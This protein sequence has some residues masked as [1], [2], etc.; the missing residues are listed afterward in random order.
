MK[1]SLSKQIIIAVLVSQLLLAIG[2]TLAIVLYSRI[3][4]LAGFDIMLE[5][6]ADS[7]LAVI[8]DSEDASQTLILD[9]Q[10]L[11]LPTSDLLEVWDEN[12]GLIWRSK[13]WQAAPAALIAST[14]PTFSLT[15]GQL[16]YRGIVVHKATIFDEE[17]NRP[18]LL[19]K[20]TIVYASSTREL[21]RRIFKIGLFAAGSSLLL[22]FFAGLFAAQ[23]V[24]RGLAPMQELATE[25]ARVSVH[26]WSF[27]PPKAARMKR[28][29]AP[30]VDALE[31]T[32][33]GLQRAFNREREFMADAAHELKTAV[34][35]LKSSLQLLSCRQ[36]SSE[37]YK[38]GL[39]R[40]LGD[41]DR[42][43]ALACSA[44][45]LARA[46]QRADEGRA[47]DLQWID[48]VNSCEQSVADLQ[49]LAQTRG[50]RLRCITKDGAI[51]KADFVDLQTIWVN[52]L[53]NAIQHSPEGST[54][55]VNV[56][57]SERGAASVV[58]EDSGTGI[59][60]EQLPHV[61]ERFR[62]GDLSRSR[63]TG[64][65]G[66]GLSI[67][68]AIV[69]AYGGH[70]QVESPNGV[71]TRVSVSLPAMASEPSEKVHVSQT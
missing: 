51:V 20:V 30:L 14:S 16:S 71:G 12:G 29:L 32:L 41:C 61:F 46:E 52:L 35:I 68:K 25:A 15:T 22:L 66:L 64:G 36:W 67:C 8:H 23:G 63:A 7:V 55:S 34:A 17:D 42:L 26:N 2:L 28:E 47:E 45:T 27:N 24:N 58:V 31:A 6:R 13:N 10:R 65:F 38:K 56:A 44:L 43:E 9:H 49:S 18:G 1:D 50:V 60:P 59:P 54:V 39:D 19:R 48:L 57:T 11:N 5:G 62:R 70:I 69:E 53:Q 21:D 33:A 37:E 4:L 40:S 3:Q